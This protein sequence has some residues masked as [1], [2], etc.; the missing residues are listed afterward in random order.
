MTPEEREKM[1]SLLRAKI[2]VYYVK[3][4]DVNREREAERDKFIKWIIE[5]IELGPEQGGVR[6]DTPL[7][8]FGNDWDAIS[9]A[10]RMRDRNRCVICGDE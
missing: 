4:P 1:D 10:V 5:Q 8:P 6:A 7:T 3:N 2:E 9:N